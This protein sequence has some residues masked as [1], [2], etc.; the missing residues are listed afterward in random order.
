MDEVLLN[1]KRGESQFSDSH[2]MGVD[3]LD[4]WLD[5]VPA[6]TSHGPV[7]LVGTWADAV[8]DEVPI[9]S[10]SIPVVLIDTL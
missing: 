9:D 5:T 6:S 3:E 2:M 8:P 10:N 1:L 4:V 7:L